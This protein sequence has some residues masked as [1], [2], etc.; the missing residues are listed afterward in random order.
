MT[1]LQDIR[2]RSTLS[3]ERPDYTTTEDTTTE[4]TTTEDTTTESTTGTTTEDTSTET[5][6]GTTTESTT[7]RTTW[8][9]TGT[10]NTMTTT[11]NTPPGRHPDTGD[12][13]PVKETAV[14]VILALMGSAGILIYKKIRKQT[15]SI[16]IGHRAGLQHRHVCSVLH[17]G[18]L[19][20]TG[21]NAH[22]LA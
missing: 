15:Y 4:D 17:G 10:T 5:T 8:S 16:E 6:T 9:T 3:T 21:K 13:L 11:R 19:R 7:E 20:N 14:V 1:I 18:V 2:F 22:S 12:R